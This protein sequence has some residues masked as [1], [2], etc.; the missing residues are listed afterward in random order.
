[1]GH[2]GVDLESSR[3]VSRSSQG[4]LVNGIADDL[5]WKIMPSADADSFTLLD[6][7]FKDPGG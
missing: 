1:V 5:Q 3:T 6:K 7:V 4:T 2:V